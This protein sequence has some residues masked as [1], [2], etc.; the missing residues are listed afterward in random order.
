MIVTYFPIIF[1]EYLNAKND[2][3]KR[4]LIN[5]TFRNI[6]S[7]LTNNDIIKNYDY[8][9]VEY[10]IGK[11][12]MADIPW[13]SFLND[14]ITKTTLNGVYCVYLFKADMSGV[15]LTLNQGVDAKVG[16]SIKKENMIKVKALI[17]SIR[18]TEFLKS[19]MQFGISLDQI[20]LKSN[21]SRGR[22]YEQATIAFKYYDS[23]SILNEQSMLNDLSIFLEIYQDYFNEN[24]Q[25]IYTKEK[26]KTYKPRDILKDENEYQ[27]K[28]ND[29]IANSFKL[30]VNERKHNMS[31]AD[32]IPKSV[33]ATTTIFIRN[34]D[35]I[36]DVLIRSNGICEL[37]GKA[38]P[39]NRRRDNSPY[40]EVHH[41]I[42][43]ANGGYDVVTN[44]IAVCPNCHRKLHFG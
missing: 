44:A 33:R 11:G 40:L 12:A 14:K 26:I 31:E 13:I 5:G 21:N 41:K 17:D 38:A 34:P 37:C 18:T 27:N 20:V 7:Y 32:I 4:E 6:Q 29:S 9:R 1:K 22:A 19:R 28:L 43:L 2:K 35:V 10:S 30:S 24:Y 39:F 42:P 15:Y 23:N 8:M 16:K 36:V 3:Q 25:S